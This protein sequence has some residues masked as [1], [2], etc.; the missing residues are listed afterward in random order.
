MENIIIIGSGPAGITAAIYT[1]RASLNPL[2]IS[3]LTP[4]GQLI[5]TSEV[6]NFPGFFQG[7]LGAELMLNFLRDNC[8]HKIRIQYIY[9]L[10]HL[11]AALI[12]S[13]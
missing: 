6:E 12:S 8:F 3:G 2:V 4:G 10:T 5:Y 7:I 1:A 11:L 13:F 9:L